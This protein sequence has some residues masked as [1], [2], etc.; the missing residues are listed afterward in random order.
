MSRKKING[1]PFIQGQRCF[2]REVN[3]NDVKGNYLKWMNDPEV[4]KFLESRFSNN[5]AESIKEFVLNIKN[6]GDSFLFAIIDQEYGKH[7][8]NVKLGPIN[9]AHRFAE[10]G[11]IIGEQSFWGK[12]YASE[13]LGLIVSYARTELK[14]HKLT[15]GCYVNNTASLKAFKKAG[16]KEE[17]LLR[18]QYIYNGLYVDAIRLGILLNDSGKEL[19]TI[20]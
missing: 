17:G 19:M 5:S 6:S 18:E 8:G 3:L 14:L 13:V 11:I 20:E 15:A 1:A 16:F 2:L 4:L 9:R 7:I 10:V 12:G